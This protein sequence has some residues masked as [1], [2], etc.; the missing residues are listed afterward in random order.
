MLRLRDS[1]QRGWR[2]VWLVLLLRRCSYTSFI[3]VA[4]LQTRVPRRAQKPAVQPGHLNHFRCSARPGE[5][6]FRRSA[7]LRAHYY[8]VH[9]F[10][11]WEYLP[12]YM[13]CTP[14]KP[15]PLR[16]CATSRTWSGV[17]FWWM[18]VDTGVYWPLSCVMAACSAKQ[19][20][21]PP[22]WIIPLFAGKRGTII[23]GGGDGIVLATTKWARG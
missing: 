5:V 10:R 7:P 11:D 9:L 4:Y 15:L 17:R 18:G 22:G 12:A 20:V 2:Y 1:K 14:P 13:R 21:I 8:L 3:P 6:R 23:Q 19:H 16:K